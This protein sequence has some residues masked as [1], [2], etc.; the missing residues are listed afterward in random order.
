MVYEILLGTITFLAMPPQPCNAP[1]HAP[2]LDHVVIAVKDLDAS[3]ASFRQLGFTIKPGRLHPNG[4]LN[5][6]VKFRDGSEIELMTVRGAATDS[7][8]RNYA[9]LI[10]SGD[11]GVYLAL[12]A[13]SMKVA[14]DA[15]IASQ[16]TTRRSSSGPWQFLGFAKCGWKV[17][18]RSWHFSGDLVPFIVVRS[19]APA[20]TLVSAG[21]LLEAARSWCCP[22]ALELVHA[23]AEFRSVVAQFGIQPFI[24]SA[25]SGFVICR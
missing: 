6:H 9:D 24:R 20:Q 12:R 14:E 16:L 23:S 11:G 5:N 8:S 3:T 7:M 25:I 19:A 21:H 2:S 10:A 22:R 13:A 18:P 15:A 1:A 17:M 4:L